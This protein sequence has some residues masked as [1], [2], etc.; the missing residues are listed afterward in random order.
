MRQTRTEAGAHWTDGTI[1]VPRRTLDEYLLLKYPFIVSVDQEDGYFVEFPDLP[2]CISLVDSIGDV[3][4]MAEDARKL[5]IEI[6]YAQG[7][8]IPEP[9]S[10]YR[11]SDQ[12]NDR[13]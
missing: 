10:F 7:I 4:A 11:S 9:G 3:R 1:L 6:A 12:L 2:G 5:W 8:E 13:P